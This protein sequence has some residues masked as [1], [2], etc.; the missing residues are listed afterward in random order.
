VV[1]TDTGEEI[2][3]RYA[4]VVTRAH[5]GIQAPLGWT[6]SN[7]S[8][9]DLRA[10]LLLEENQMELAEIAHWLGGNLECITP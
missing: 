7:A 8:M 1:N 10:Q 9:D 4:R 5:P 3:S 2:A 6:L